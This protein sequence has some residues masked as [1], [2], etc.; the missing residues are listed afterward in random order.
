MLTP[1]LQKQRQRNTIIGSLK[2]TIFALSIFVLLLF[3][4]HNAD[5]NFNRRKL[6]TQTDLLL[7]DLL[8]EG[9]SLMP[10]EEKAAQFAPVS[11]EA[12]FEITPLYDEEDASFIGK[13]VEIVLFESESPSAEQ[14]AIFHKVCTGGLEQNAK[15]QRHVAEGNQS[16]KD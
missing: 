1:Q 13:K 7:S 5:T 9:E 6:Q 11:L 14:K 16:L 3:I 12:T 2:W 4:I 15:R 10:F 8:G